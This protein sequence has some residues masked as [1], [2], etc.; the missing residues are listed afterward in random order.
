MT[1]KREIVLDIETTG[2]D[3]KDGH[4][5]IE[6]AMLELLDGKPTGKTLH[7]YIN[8]EREVP[9]DAV[10][11]HGLT[12]DFLKDKSKFKDVAQE[13]LD[14]IGDSNIVAH[15]AFFDMVFFNAE[16]DSAG[17]AKFPWNRAVDTL[18]IS[19]VKNPYLP[20]YHTLDKLCRHYHIDIPFRDIPGTLFDAQLFAKVYA[21]M[22]YE[23]QERQTDK[24]F[25]CVVCK[26]V[27]EGYPKCNSCGRQTTIKNM[28]GDEATLIHR[29][30]EN[31]WASHTP[32]RQVVCM[33]ALIG[34]D[35]ESM[36]EIRRSGSDDFDDDIPFGS[37]AYDYSKFY[38]QVSAVIGKYHDVIPIETSVRDE[39]GGQLETVGLIM[40][41]QMGHK[42]PVSFIS[43]RHVRNE[44]S[45][46]MPY[47][48]T[49]CKETEGLSRGNFI[50]NDSGV[51]FT[52]EHPLHPYAKTAE[53]KKKVSEI[54][55]KNLGI[56]KL[57]WLPALQIGYLSISNL[58]N[59][60]ENDTLLLT[61]GY[62]KET[63]EYI[64]K[65]LEIIKKECPELK[66]DVLPCNI[67]EDHYKEQLYIDFIETKHAVFVAQYG[68]PEDELAIKCFK[69]H[70]KKPV[71]G[72]DCSGMSEWCFRM[73]NVIKVYWV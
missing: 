7:H 24:G 62:N 40:P 17:F 32:S 31:A 2:Y 33:Y 14:F 63:R 57:V 70:T 26:Y 21:K 11:I 34:F 37:F 9:E 71:V 6:I 3:P 69:T 48:Y 25:V 16:L 51:A 54:L 46:F 38:E 64:A 20:K 13:I 30:F 4:K 56:K 39:W 29:F 68:K 52:T 35:G 28:P 12:T 41:F 72:I 61:E 8:P 60:I 19:D 73:S 44:I 23:D 59:F 18:A 55:K 49:K 36:A 10:K 58:I 45:R 50:Y 1:A 5:I 22:L 43:D 53:A 47:D 65:C 42:K 67:T 66:T 27:G 15:N